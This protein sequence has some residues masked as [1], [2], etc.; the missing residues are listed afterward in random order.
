MSSGLVTMLIA[1]VATLAIRSGFKIAPSLSGKA[2]EVLDVVL[3]ALD[4]VRTGSTLIGLFV[5][6]EPT[7]E[8][9]AATQT[10]F[11]DAQARYRARIAAAEAEGAT[12]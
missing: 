4:T 9:L 11:D 3:E 5:D 7:E 1:E 12:T 8:E 6:D 10:D 2:R